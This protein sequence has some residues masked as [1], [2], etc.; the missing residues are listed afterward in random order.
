M[1]QVGFIYILKTLINYT[2][3]LFIPKNWELLER[4]LRVD[5][6]TGKQHVSQ[7]AGYFWG[8]S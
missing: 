1:W 2:A 4:F 5:S 7:N 6:P 3:D 8:L